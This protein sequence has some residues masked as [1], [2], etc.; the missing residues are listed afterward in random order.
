MDIDIILFWL[1]LFSA[2]SLLANQRGA[3]WTA[4]ALALI[5]GA[6]TLVLVWPEAAGWAVAAA[7]AIFLALP[8]GLAD[9]A[10]RL[11]LAQNLQSARQVAIIAAVLHPDR[12]FRS[13]AWF[14]GALRD[15]QR[16]RFDRAI[17]RF[18][19]LRSDPA[20]PTELRL[21]AHMHLRRLQDRWDDF[22]RETCWD[23]VDPAL[24]TLCRMRAFSAL[25]RRPDMIALQRSGAG[26]R[27]DD[28]GRGVASSLALMYLLTA[29][30][31]V[32][33]LAALFRGP[34]RKLG[35]PTRALQLA[36]AAR[37][38]RAREM[39]TRLTANSD[40]DVARAAALALD[41]PLARVE[42]TDDQRGVVAGAERT[43]TGNA[44]R[45]AARRPRVAP[46]TAILVAANLV[47]FAAEVLRGGSED[48][49]ALRSLGALWTPA[50]LGRTE[51][52]RVGAALFLHYGWVHLA[53][54]M[55]SLLVVGSATERL[56]GSWRTLAVYLAAGLGSMAMVVALA[57]LH[58]SPSEFVV[59]ASGAIMGL[60]GALLAFAIRAWRRNRVRAT[61]VRVVWVAG[62]IVLQS[63]LDVATPQI[64]F[65]GHLSG[66]VI[67]LLIG[68]LLA[69]P[70]SRDERLAVVQSAAARRPALSRR[71]LVTTGIGA[72]AALAASLALPR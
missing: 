41:R 7:W 9:L 11:A 65:T 63:A 13:Q 17:A 6:G 32:D 36:L 15:A 30:G 64:S 55:L 60:I 24:A 33:P 3:L 34:L 45:R 2:V 70:K 14:L 39:L 31:R 35:A 59:G 71:G 51:W 38:E 1:A 68:T 62:A 66:V 40:R 44:E 61:L 47:V 67:G 57:A 4:K 42:L 25:D 21:S 37:D 53:V 48:A 10:G 27:A 12:R 16:G 8:T 26:V 43:I 58:V 19:T 20:T 46:V 72:V 54:N 5:F 28:A 52:W 50:V 49:R 69:P 22:L 18:D 29:C 23:G 56:F